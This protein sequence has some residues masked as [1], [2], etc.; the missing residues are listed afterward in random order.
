MGKENALGIICLKHVKN[1][2]KIKGYLHKSLQAKIITFVSYQIDNFIS[3]I[4]GLIGLATW[5]SWSQIL[6]PDMILLEKLA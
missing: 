4:V 6:V 1:K 5:D 3:K 2:L